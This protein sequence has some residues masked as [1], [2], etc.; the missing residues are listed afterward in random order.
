MILTFG[1]LSPDKGIEYVIEAMPAIV[2]R[3]PNAVYRRARR[4]PSA[5][6]GAARR[7]LSARARDPARASSASK[8]A[9]SFTIASCSL[10][11]LTEFLS[12]ADIYI[13]PYLNP[14]QITS[15]TLAYAVGAGKAVISTPYRYAR[16]L[17]ADERGVLVPVRD[18]AAIAEAAERSARATTTSCARSVSARLH[19]A[20]DM[21]W[22]TWRAATSRASSARSASTAS[23]RRAC[24]EAKT[25]AKRPVDLPELNLE[26]LR[27]MTDDT[28]MLQ[29]AAFSV[30]RYEDGY[31]LDDNARALLL[32]GAARG[33]RQR[34]SPRAHP[35]ACVALPRLRE[36][37]VQ[38]RL[39]G[40][41][42]T[43]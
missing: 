15:G 38:P 23:L 19:T 21:L 43:S 31:C 10:R 24:F 7:S 13:T 11:E 34:R 42:E 30:P 33:R 22:P 37:R 20:R 12:A 28:G 40:A 17:L 18:S 5:R 3:H 14:E 26:H 36:P 27:C 35:R 41:F 32:D 4:H 8:R 39:R 6:Q 16:E 25:L 2:E 1:L 29:H 9:S